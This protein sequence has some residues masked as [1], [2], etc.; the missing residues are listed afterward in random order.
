[1]AKIYKV[2]LFDDRQ[3]GKRIE[4][5]LPTNKCMVYLTTNEDAARQMYKDN[6]EYLHARY[7]HNSRKPGDKPGISVNISTTW[8]FDEQGVCR[9]NWDTQSM[10]DY[11][12]T[13]DI[14]Y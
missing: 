13:G 10:F 7:E 6:I 1:M 11:L 2:S 4:L 14:E 8:G 12:V 9:W 5:G 3:E